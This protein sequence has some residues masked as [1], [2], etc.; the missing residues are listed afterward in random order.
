MAYQKYI[1]LLSIFI[2]CIF[3][4]CACTEPAIMPDEQPPEPDNTP[5]PI[6]SD[7]D[8]ELPGAIFVM[9]DDHPNARPQL[10]LDKADIVYEVVCEWTYTRFLAGFFS[11][12]PLKIGPI[13]SARYYYAQIVMPY[14]SPYVHVGGN[15][16]A[17]QFIEDNGINHICDITNASGYF[18]RDSSRKAPHNSYITTASVLKYANRRNYS[19]SP[20]PGL[21]VSELTGGR[22]AIQVDLIYGNA[23]YK[24]NVSWQYQETNGRYLRYLND[25]VLK[26]ATD[27]EVYADN[28]IIIEAPVKTVQV[29]VDG[30]QSKIDL[31]GTGRAVFMRN[32]QMFTGIWQKDSADEHFSY[33]L[34]DGRMWAYTKGN[35]WVQQVHSIEKNCTVITVDTP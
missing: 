6:E 17:L 21:L 31:I 4:L 9:I 28:I 22:Q 18:E 16:D 14:E 27:S 32:G 2:A 33:R 7:P 19:L 10:N 30:V 8:P 24:H 11:I 20:L 3:L 13:R 5:E 15:M 26:T 1:K 35:V 34:D 23:E 12:D 25:E 29:P